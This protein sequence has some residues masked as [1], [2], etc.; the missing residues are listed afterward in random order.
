[1]ILN[2]KIDRYW[3]LQHADVELESKAALSRCLA[4]LTQINE[5]A[6]KQVAEADP[7]E[8][9]DSL[10]SDCCAV[11]IPSRKRPSHKSQVR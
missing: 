11:V 7:S 1:M 5:E 10:T 2:I 9:C 8:F 3:S 6:R 4:V